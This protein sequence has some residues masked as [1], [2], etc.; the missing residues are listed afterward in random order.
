M[1]SQDGGA[2]WRSTGP[3]GDIMALAIDSA[4]PNI[5]YTGIAERGGCVYSDHRLFKTM[6]GGE[7]WTTDASP[8]INGCDN[9]HA[10]LIDSTQANTLY[11]AS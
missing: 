1:K 6:N 7:S 9:I 11:L 3:T 5:L 10:L 4:D 8:P 2:T